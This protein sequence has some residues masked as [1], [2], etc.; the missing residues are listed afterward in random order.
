MK[1]LNN[2]VGRDEGKELLY[3]EA[4]CNGLWLIN[5]GMAG[6]LAGRKCEL[7]DVIE[8]RKDIYVSF[9]LKYSVFDDQVLLYTSLYI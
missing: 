9:L 5:T 3:Y 7:R 4:K 8:Y 1:D 2:V 6:R